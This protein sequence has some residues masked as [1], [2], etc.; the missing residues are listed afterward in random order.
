MEA[1]KA[2]CQKWGPY[3]GHIISWQSIPPALRLQ[4]TVLKLER[5]ERLYPILWEMLPRLLLYKV[6]GFHRIPSPGWG[7]LCAVIM[8]WGPPKKPHN[9][10][11]C[12]NISKQRNSCTL[13]ISKT[14]L[15]TYKNQSG[16]LGVRTR[17]SF[18]GPTSVFESSEGFV[19]YIYNPWLGTRFPSTHGT[20]CGPFMRRFDVG[21]VQD[22]QR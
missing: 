4:V 17:L 11:Q 13:R 7:K 3:L 2:I 5:R 19:R 8:T 18:E 16:V 12:M 15:R 6:F 10:I 20:C 14:E 21:A 9:G 22:L 1:V